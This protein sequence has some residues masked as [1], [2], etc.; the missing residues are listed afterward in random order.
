MAGSI[1]RKEEIPWSTPTNPRNGLSVAEGS[2]Q[3]S[4]S[5]MP[6]IPPEPRPQ[7]LSISSGVAAAQFDHI[8]SP[9]AQ[10]VE[11]TP[12]GPVWPP[13]NKTSAGPVAPQGASSSQLG[14]LV[15]IS[16][17]HQQFEDGGSNRPQHEERG[18]SGFPYPAAARQPHLIRRRRTSPTQ[19][20]PGPG[21]HI[22]PGRSS[23]TA[24]QPSSTGTVHND[25]D[26]PGI[27]R[28]Q[29]RRNRNMNDHVPRPGRRGSVLCSRCRRMKQGKRV[30]LLLMPISNF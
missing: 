2:L 7:S 20:A 3:S 16:G 24:P 5:G 23:Y 11:V 1:Y 22:H 13:S 4:Y 8:D 27:H 18:P 25:T 9:T 28:P 6:A 21:C 12:N 15:E 30:R 26:R 14:P 19:L 10:A 17:D 29:A